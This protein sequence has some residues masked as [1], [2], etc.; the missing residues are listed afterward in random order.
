MQIPVTKTLTL[1]V[2]HG[3]L[4]VD[5]TKDGESYQVTY[6]NKIYKNS[7]FVFPTTFST[8]FSVQEIVNSNEVRA[9]IYQI[10]GEL[11]E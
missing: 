8:E 6:H 7:P 11:P 5:K 9:K 3:Y 2:P 4:S 1:S 10:T